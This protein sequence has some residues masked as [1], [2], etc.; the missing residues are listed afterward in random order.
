MPAEGNP[1]VGVLALGPVR[2]NDFSF[3]FLIKNKTLVLQIPPN[4]AKLFSDLSCTAT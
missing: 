3:F 1:I 2:S 4:D